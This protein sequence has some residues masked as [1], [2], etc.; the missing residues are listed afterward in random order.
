MKPDIK[1]VI[2]TN[3]NGGVISYSGGNKDVRSIHLY[4]SGTAAKQT[5][6]PAP[7]KNIELGAYEGAASVNACPPGAYD[8][9]L[10]MKNDTKFEWRKN[11]IVKTG[12]RTEVK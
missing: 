1:Y 10:A 4:P 12:S 7:Q 6:T 3:L 5:G 11:L 9:L 8:I 2:S